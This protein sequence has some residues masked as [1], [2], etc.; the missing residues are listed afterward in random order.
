MTWFE[1][2]GLVQMVIRKYAKAIAMRAAPG[3]LFFSALL[4]IG[5][6]GLAAWMAIATLQKESIPF[7][8]LRNRSGPQSAFVPYSGN[9]IYFLIG[10]VLFIGGMAGI[11][12]V[13]GRIRNASR[14]SDNQ[15]K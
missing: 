3:M 8:F 11:G 14:P 15:N 12:Q 7:I 9:V 13:L 2:D 6:L 4:I 5:G 10:C 1:A